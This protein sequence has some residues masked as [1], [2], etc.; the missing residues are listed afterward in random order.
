MVKNAN[1]DTKTSIYLITLNFIW[2]TFNRLLYQKDSIESRFKD[3][4]KNGLKLQQAGPFLN[5]RTVSRYN[6][7]RLGWNSFLA[8]L[9][10]KFN[11][12]WIGA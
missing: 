9:E 7:Q 2:H 5:V 10:L 12:S 6:L 11:W 3:A 1:F 4:Y 8:G